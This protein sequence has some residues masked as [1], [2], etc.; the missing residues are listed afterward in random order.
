MGIGSLPIRLVYTLF[1]PFP[2]MGG[3]MGLQ[4]GKIDTLIFYFFMYRAAIATR[5]LLRTNRSTLISL[6]A[7]IVPCTVAYAFTMANMGLMLRQRLPIVA[8]VALLATLSWPSRE[9]VLRASEAR[10]KR[11]DERAAA[12]KKPSLVPLPTTA[13]L[14]LAAGTSDRPKDGA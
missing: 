7:F 4:L 8:M 10:K 6:L 5:K 2:W 12:R 9:E 1:S 13:G 3:T 14:A 11:I